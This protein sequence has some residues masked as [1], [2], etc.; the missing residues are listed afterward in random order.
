M[1]ITDSTQFAQKVCG[2]D[3]VATL[4]LNR[5]DEDGGHLFGRKDGLEEFFLNVA[6]AAQAEGFLLLRSARKT[7]ICPAAIGVGIADVRHA[8]NQR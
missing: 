3:D 2:R 1:P 7:V 4:A 5:L 6:R 8:R